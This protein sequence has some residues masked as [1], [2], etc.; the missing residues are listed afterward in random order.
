[1]TS[2]EG[3][4]DAIVPVKSSRHP[5]ASGASMIAKSSLDAQRADDGGSV[6]EPSVLQ[7]NVHFAQRLH[8]T[9]INDGMLTD[10]RSAFLNHSELKESQHHN[11]SVAMASR[12]SA[13]TKRL[14]SQERGGRVQRPRSS[15]GYRAT[16]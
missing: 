3:E 9:S 15:K 6:N 10:D 2:L 14:G 4:V 8:D 7:D 16:L 11:L 5:H 12:H 13:S 1:M